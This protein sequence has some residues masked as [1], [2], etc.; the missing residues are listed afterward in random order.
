MDTVKKYLPEMLTGLVGLLGLAYI[1]SEKST[2]KDL[3]LG[4]EHYSIYK[5]MMF[6]MFFLFLG[7][8]YYFTKTNVIASYLSNILFCI[9]LAVLVLGFIYTF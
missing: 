7:A 8:V 6:I 3:P 2:K 1:V 4:L 5:S 9:L